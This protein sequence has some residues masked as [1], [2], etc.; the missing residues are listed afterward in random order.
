MRFAR[1]A[2]SNLYE[3]LRSEIGRQFFRN[4][5]G[6][7][8]LGSKVMMPCFWVIESFP[9]LK[10]SFSDLRRNFP[11]SIQKNLRNSEVNPSV[12]GDFPFF[13]FLRN[14][15]SSSCV[16]FPVLM[17]ATSSKIT[18][19]GQLPPSWVSGFVSPHC[20]NSKWSASICGLLHVFAVSPFL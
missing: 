11:I 3:V 1:Q 18:S 6:L 19:F 10:L 8:P 16:N 2:E 12:P 17:P 14:L 4:S 20:L 9:I 13:A 15:S 7:S 5:L